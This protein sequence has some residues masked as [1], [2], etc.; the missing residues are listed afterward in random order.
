MADETLHSLGTAVCCSSRASTCQSAPLDSGDVRERGSSPSGSPQPGAST[1]DVLQIPSGSRADP[2]PGP[3]SQLVDGATTS[4]VPTAL[5]ANGTAVS[6]VPSV[7]LISEEAGS[8]S[9]A[10]LTVEEARMLV[11]LF[12]LPYHHGPQAQHLLE[13]LRW[14]R[15][16][17]PSMGV[18]SRSPDSCVVRLMWALLR[19]SALCSCSDA[20]PVCRLHSGAAGPVPSGSSVPRCAACTAASSAVR[21]RRCSTTCTPTCGTSATCCWLP[22]PLCCGW[23]RE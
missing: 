6:P 21:G 3:I 19:H 8:D 2:S 23:V 7:P 16:N 15:A 1:A 4:P 22:A 20:C 11:E 18:P 12:Y 13:D 14:L 17:G 9:G 10:P 5:F